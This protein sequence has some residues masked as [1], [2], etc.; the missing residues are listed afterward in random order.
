MK[1]ALITGASSGF[2]LETAKLLS[3]EGYRLILVARRRN[4]L[5]RLKRE[6]PSEVYVGALDVTNKKQVAAFFSEL[7]KEFK[8]ID[9]LVNSA[10]MAS[11]MGPIQ[12]SEIDELEKMVDTNIKGLLYIT[13]PVVKMMKQRG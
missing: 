6:L 7:P 3:K 2:G 12:E 1:T 9:I 5:E 10:G 4:V 13:H 8:N 11:G